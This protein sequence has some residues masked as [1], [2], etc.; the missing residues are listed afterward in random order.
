RTGCPMPR[1][2]PAR[3]SWTR[4]GSRSTFRASATRSAPSTRSRR[5]PRS[6]A[7]RRTASRSTRSFGE[8]SVA[9]VVAVTTFNLRT[10][11]LRSGEQFQDEREIRLEPLELGGQR[12][13]PVPETVPAGLAITRASTGTVFELEFHVRL[14]GPCFRC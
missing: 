12:Y 7:P 2:P 13:Q 10:L 6:G 8:S 1:P 3:S 11:R 9:T 14:H 5:G 4:A